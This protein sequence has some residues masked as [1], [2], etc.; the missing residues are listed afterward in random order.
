MGLRTRFH[1]HGHGY[2]LPANSVSEDAKLRLYLN[3]RVKTN[4][5]L[6]RNRVMHKICY[7]PD[8]LVQWFN[9]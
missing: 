1:P 7:L 5:G 2:P 4:V 6:G 8:E 9:A 3:S